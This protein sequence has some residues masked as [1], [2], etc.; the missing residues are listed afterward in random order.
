MACPSKGLKDFTYN[1]YKNVWS[2]HNLVLHENLR[3]GTSGYKS[4][5]CTSEGCS[6]KYRI[7][8]YIEYK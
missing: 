2:E 6:L 8:T 5:H 4:F 3:I 7:R 1:D